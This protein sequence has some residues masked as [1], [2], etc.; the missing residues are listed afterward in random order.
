MFSLF[1]MHFL[2][3]RDPAGPVK[4]RTPKDSTDPGS[5]AKKH[6]RI[7]CESYIWP[8]MTEI[9]LENSARTE[10]Q[11][12][13]AFLQ[14]PG[15]QAFFTTRLGG[16]SQ[17]AY[18][19]LNLGAFSGDTPDR[20]RRNWSILLESRGFSGRIPVLPRLCHGAAL[21][22]VRTETEAEAT[23]DQPADALFTRTPGLVIA[24]TMAD[25]LAALIVD[26]ETR[27]V[28]AVHAGWRGTRENILGSTLQ[29]LFA[30]GQ[31]EPG[32]TFVALGPCLSP[33]A[34]EIGDEVAA[35]LPAAHLR[36]DIPGNPG[37]PHFDL[38]G[39]NRAQALAAGIAPGN[40][41]E[42]GGCTRENPDLFFSYRRDQGVT[43][44][45][46]ACIALESR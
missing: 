46:A 20:V 30:A 18:A 9:A 43:G 17:G 1:S 8:Q 38:R 21:L 26:P 6:R 23:S 44:R 22:E 7:L 40:V 5:P 32:T 37:R 25:C 16:V 14:I 2:T 10:P 29:R 42:H 31:C 24:V 39:C 3:T 12:L 13:P 41:T 11:V 33:A 15:V 34:L 27:C 36:F 35:T 45:M 4:K 28:A 19:S